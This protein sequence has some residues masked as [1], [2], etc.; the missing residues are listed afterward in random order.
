MDVAE[1]EPPNCQMGYTREQI[2][3]IVGEHGSHSRIRFHLWMSGQT[4]AI[5]DGR[6][7][8][9]EA[10]KYGPTGCGPHGPIVYGHDVRR[11][12]AGLP[13]LD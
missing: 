6:E 3:R 11:F 5:C 8:D 13:V 10:R 2:D 4:M 1:I 12:L 7:Y 9:H